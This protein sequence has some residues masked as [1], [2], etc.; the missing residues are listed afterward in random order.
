[1]HIDLVS[2]LRNVGNKVVRSLVGIN[3]CDIEGI[4]HSP[5]VLFGITF[6]KPNV[7][8]P[9][10]VKCIRMEVVGYIAAVMRK[11]RSPGFRSVG[12]QLG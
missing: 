6:N 2:S 4:S 7:C 1:M 9:S 8:L 11:P 3:D 5:P 12:E 10:G